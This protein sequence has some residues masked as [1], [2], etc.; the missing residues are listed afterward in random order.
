RCVSETVPGQLALYVTLYSPLQMA[1][2][3]PE[4]YQR[5]MDAFQFIKDVPVEWERSVYLEAEPM[6]YVTIARKDKNSDAWFVGS[7]AGESP[8]KSQI[9][10]DFLDPGRKYNATIYADDPSGKQ[11][12]LI[13]TRKVNSKSNLKIDARTGGGYAISIVP[14]Q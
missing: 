1:A 4:H 10:L 3:L 2:D 12:Y 8:R 7:T 13:S 14:V 11:P 6:E 5:H 9:S